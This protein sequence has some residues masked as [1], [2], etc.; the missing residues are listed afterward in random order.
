MEPKASVYATC[1][2]SKSFLEISLE[3]SENMLMLQEN[4]SP[5]SLSLFLLSN[6]L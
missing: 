4:L 5:K 6:K 2:H 3:L 1:F